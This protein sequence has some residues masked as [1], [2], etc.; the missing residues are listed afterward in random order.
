MK[1]LLALMMALALLLTTA[2]AEDLV[3]TGAVEQKEMTDEELIALIHP[4]YPESDLLSHKLPEDK[5]TVTVLTHYSLGVNA[6]RFKQLFGGELVEVI[7]SVDEYS[8]KLQNMIAAGNPPDLVVAES[9]T[10]NFILTM[11]KPGLVQPFDPYIDYSVPELADLQAAYDA[12]LWNDQHYLAP[13]TQRPLYYMIYNPL[14]F[15]ENGLETPWELWERGEWTWDA[16]REYAQLL[17]VQNE[18]GAWV[19]FGTAIPAYGTLTSTTGVDYV[20]LSNGEVA[21]NLHDP[22]IVRAENFINDMLYKDYIIK[23][24]AQDAWKGYW[25]R[26]MLAMQIVA[27]WTFSGDADIAKAARN[28]RLGVCPLPQDPE[29]CEVGVYNTWGQSGGFCLVNGAQNPEGAALLVRM[30]AYTSRYEVPELDLTWQK[31]LDSLHEQGFTNEVLYQQHEAFS[32]D[33]ALISFGYGIMADRGV[34]GFMGAQNNWTSHVETILP[35]VEETI[36]EMT[37]E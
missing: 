19:S 26:G 2:M 12:G 1:K 25:N 6:D 18:S 22:A 37:E 16:F 24:N 35:G 17:N 13:Y 5:K 31:S 8:S 27:S 4:E 7:C 28:G 30:L 34:W 29:N 14:I 3:F 9:C 21:I 11:V 33:N 32:M 23:I 36:R 20:T 10:S 15:E